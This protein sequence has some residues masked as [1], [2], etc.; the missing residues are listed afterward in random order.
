MKLGG[1]IIMIVCM[2]MFLEFLAI[3]TGASN[4]LGSFGV[5]ITPAT[6]KLNSADLEASSF[7]SW[8]F[9]TGAGIFFIIGTVGAVLIGLFGRSY[10]T[11]LVILPLVIS[12]GSLLAST[13]WTI[14]K[15]MQSIGPSWATNIVALILFGIGLGFIMACVDYFAGR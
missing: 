3:P 12:V 10:D 11:S 8:I 14:I 7:F 5:D 13:I 9:G 1:F 2:I 15:Y 4:I 6:G